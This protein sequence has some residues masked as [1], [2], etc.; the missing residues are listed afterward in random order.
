MDIPGWQLHELRGELAGY[1][2]V[3]VDGNRRLTFRFRE[4]DA[5]MVDL[6]DYH[7]KEGRCRY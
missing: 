2:D 7:W 1:W 5:E 3:S 4:G 6:Q